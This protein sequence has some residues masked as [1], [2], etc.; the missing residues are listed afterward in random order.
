MSVKIKLVKADR[1]TL[2]GLNNNEPIKR[3]EVVEV[4][5]KMAAILLGVTRKN[6][7]GDQMS[8]FEKVASKTPKKPKAKPAE[9]EAS[10]AEEAP[11]EVVPEAV[12]TPQTKSRRK[13][14][15]DSTSG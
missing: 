7:E 10:E 13:Q 9:A 15:P 12:D 1:Y 2:V 5:D 3:N 14:K 11:A 8:V 4:P 6:K